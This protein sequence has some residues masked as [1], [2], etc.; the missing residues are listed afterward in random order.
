MASSYVLDAHTVIW[1]LEDNPRLGPAAKRILL[2]P[3]VALVLPAIALAEACWLVE[4]KRSTIPTTADLLGSVDADPRIVVHSLDREVVGRSNTRLAVLEMHD[5]QIVA[6][7]LLLID[8]G[9]SVALLTRDVNITA[10][11]LVPTIW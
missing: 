4:R 9:H 3:S 2:D 1:F 5:R 8:Q 10:S 6:T 11:G 7:A